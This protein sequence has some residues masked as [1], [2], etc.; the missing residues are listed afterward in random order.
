MLRARSIAA[1]AALGALLPGLAPA[2]PPPRVDL[3]GRITDASG[4]GI[5][6]VPVRLLQARRDFKV[7]DWEYED[8]VLDAVVARSDADGFFEATLAPDPDFR[9]FWLRFFDPSSFDPVRYARP[10][11]LDVT[12]P[13]RA[14]RPVIRMVVV[15]DAPGWAEVSAWIERLGSDSP[16]GLLV[17]RLGIPDR[18]TSEGELETFFYES[19]GV[20]YRF[21][22][23]ELVGEERGEG[24]GPGADGS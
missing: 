18:H 14:G 7:L 2:A 24:A 5:A 8:S 10:A 15:D 9:S 23:G 6:G 13:V 21:R 22:D 20:A 16:R 19:A 3:R 1:V 12:A 4:R 11:D 17:R